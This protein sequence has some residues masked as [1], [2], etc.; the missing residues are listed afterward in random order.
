[1]Q[2]AQDGGAAI[3]E[4][5]AGKAAVI[6]AVVAWVDAAIAADRKVGGA[7]PDVGDPTLGAPGLLYLRFRGGF[8]WQA[9]MYM[10]MLPSAYHR[11]DVLCFQVGALKQLQGHIWRTGFQRGEVSGVLGAAW[12]CLSMDSLPAHARSSYAIQV[13]LSLNRE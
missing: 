13:L 5:G 4:A 6:D 9:G 8:F 7:Y 2:A 1:M 3:P 10:L 11:Y 12:G